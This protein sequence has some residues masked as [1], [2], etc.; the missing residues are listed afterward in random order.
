MEEK[1][2]RCP[3]CKKITSLEKGFKKE[4]I[5]QVNGICWS[6]IGYS[7]GGWGRR[8]NFIHSFSGEVCN[9][10]FNDLKNM[11][12]KFNEVFQKRRNSQDEGICIYKTQRNESEGDKMPNVQRNKLQSKRHKQSLLRLLPFLS[13]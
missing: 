9:E 3:V 2:N 1:I 13:R 8:R 11:I 4:K 5:E 7:I 12:D 6:D 10:C